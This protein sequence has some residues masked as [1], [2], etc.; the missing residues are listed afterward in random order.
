MLTRLQTYLRKSVPGMQDSEVR[1][2]RSIAD[3]WETDIYS[4]DLVNMQASGWANDRLI[5][6]MYPGTHAE[7]GAKWEFTVL[8]QLSG[9]GYPVPLVLHLE[10]S[11]SPLG[12]PFIIMERIEGCQLWDMFPDAP[13][14]RLHELVHMASKLFVDLHQLEW[15]K[16][17]PVPTG[18]DTDDPH[19]FIRARLERYTTNISRFQ[20]KE[21]MPLVDW[22]KSHLR[23]IPVGRLSFTHGDFHPGNILVDDSGRHFV[24]DWTASRVTDS[25]VDLAWTLLLA[26]TFPG[27][28]DG[29]ILSTYEEISGSE[30]VSIEYFE[31]LAILRRLLDMSVSFTLGS[32]ERRMREGA[33]EM[34]REQSD[35]FRKVHALLTELTGINIPEIATLIESIAE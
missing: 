28:L 17:F 5:L 1:N 29:I 31:V 2:L 19:S 20:K 12:R 11:S 27:D 7:H 10:Q 3:G 24:I 13:P 35:H 30:V 15:M 21:L 16:A 32:G 9:L 14:D 6:R 25:R 34:M 8:E 4:F 26:K 23:D 18:R 33:L 22:L